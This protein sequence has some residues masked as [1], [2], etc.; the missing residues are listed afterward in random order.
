MSSSKELLDKVVDLIN[1]AK[2]EAKE[3]KIYLLAQASLP[4]V[5]YVSGTQIYVPADEPLLAS[6]KGAFVYRWR[7]C[8]V[9]L[10]YCTG[11]SLGCKVQ[12]ASPLY[13]FPLWFLIIWRLGRDLPGPQ[14]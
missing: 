7:E 5:S 9:Q 6:A 11:T 2:V 13:K 1:N 12:M 10:Q 3:Q 4:I 14:R 8:N